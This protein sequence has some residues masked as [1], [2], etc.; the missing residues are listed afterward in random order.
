MDQLVAVRARRA[1]PLLHAA[2]VRAW[3]R[4]WWCLLAVAVQDAVAATLVQDKP[5]ELSAP[6]G[7]PEP[8]LTDVLDPMLT[9]GEPSNFDCRM[10]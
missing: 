6:A 4:R 1:P 3:Q 2:A 5:T 7:F 8:W 10:E 9:A